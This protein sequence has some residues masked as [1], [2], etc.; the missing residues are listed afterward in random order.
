MSYIAHEPFLHFDIGKEHDFL[1]F[2]KY[3]I[4]LSLESKAKANHDISQQ[5]SIT[6]S[7]GHNQL[8]IP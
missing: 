2:I 5:S 4:I 6:K 8:Q 1:W 7:C 3:K